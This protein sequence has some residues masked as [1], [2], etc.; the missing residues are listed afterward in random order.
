MIGQDSEE[1]ESDSAV[2][3]PGPGSPQPQNFKPYVPEDFAN[4][5]VYN[6][7][8]ETL[9]AG[10]CASEEKEVSRSPSASTC[11][12]G[13]VSHS[14]STATLSDVLFSG[15]ESCDQIT[16]RDTSDPQEHT[17]GHVLS[18]SVPAQRCSRRRDGCLMS[19][20]QEFTDFKGADDGEG[21]NLD[22]FETGSD[23]TSQSHL[24]NGEGSLEL[25]LE[26]AADSSED[27]NAPVVQLPDWMAPGEQV[28]VGEWIGTVHYVGGVEFAKGIWVGVELDLAVGTSSQIESRSQLPQRNQETVTKKP[29]LFFTGKHNGTVQGRVYFRCATG[30]GVFVRPSRLTRGPPSID[31]KH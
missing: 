2:S 4:F 13:Y 24:H 8:L 30:H 17:R 14:A 5:E 9:E 20:S 12:S 28:W 31:P 29:F 23:T 3:V 7:S 19:V 27:E 10:V 22:G 21:G 18:F 26:D 15:S 6:A 1:E 11:T 16:T 25:G